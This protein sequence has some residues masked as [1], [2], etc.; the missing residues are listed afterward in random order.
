M[1]QMRRT[2]INQDTSAK[3]LKIRNLVLQ[4]L[5]DKNWVDLDSNENENRTAID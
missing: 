1:L 2:L 5:T 3:S 4:K